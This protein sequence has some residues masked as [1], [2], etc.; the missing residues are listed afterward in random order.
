VSAVSR[1][2]SHIDVFWAGPDGTVIVMWWGARAGGSWNEHAPIPIS[3]AGA[4]S[5]DVT[6]AI[7][8]ASGLLAESARDAAAGKA[9]EAVDAAQQAVS[10]LERADATADRRLDYLTM[11]AEALHT[12]VLRL[13]A[14]GRIPEAVAPAS[15]AVASYRALADAPGADRVA[16]ARS[17]LDLCGQ[18][19]PAQQQSAA[20]D[21]AEAAAEILGGMTPPVPP[22]LGFLGLRAEALHTLVLRLIAAGRIPEAVAPASL[23]VA[24]YVSLAAVSDVHPVVVSLRNLSQALTSAG[25][26]AAALDAE[27]AA[28]RLTAE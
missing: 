3:P 10:V 12:L 27:Q 7:G 11:R 18:I 19:T 25:L 26:D 2:A 13:I 8:T 20:V 28:M 24:A 17:L 15:L 16:V 9:A 6:A 14:A 4:V 22:D 23:A 5:Y 1:D 21:A